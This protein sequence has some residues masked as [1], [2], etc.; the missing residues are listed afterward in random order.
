MEFI[1]EYIAM[2]YNPFD[3]RLTSI[4]FG[5]FIYYAIMTVIF[6]WHHLASKYGSLIANSLL[7][8]ISLLGCSI[9][10]VADAIFGLLHGRVIGVYDSDEWQLYLHM[11][12]FVLV[13]SIYALIIF[14]GSNKI[15]SIVKKHTKNKRP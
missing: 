15:I 11:F 13:Y 14:H 1:V 12:V 10:I 8:I 4:T 3:L 9:V 6:V 5:Y 2:V 7:V